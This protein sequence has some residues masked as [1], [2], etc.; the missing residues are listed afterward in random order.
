MNLTR[1]TTSPAG[2]RFLEYSREFVVTDDAEP[3]I[4]EALRAMMDNQ[5]SLV[6]DCFA[7]PKPWSPG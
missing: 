5:I 1:P 7:T 6:R 2:L 4:A 3:G